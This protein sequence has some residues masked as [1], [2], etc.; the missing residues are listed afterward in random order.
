MWWHFVAPP[1]IYVICDVMIG[2]IFTGVTTGNP[3]VGGSFR[4]LLKDALRATTAAPTF[5]SPLQVIGWVRGN[6]NNIL[7][8]TSTYPWQK[9]DSILI[10]FPFCPL[11]F[12]LFP[13]P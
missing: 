7:S 12:L 3:N 4:F 5:F 1:F 2:P 13:P 8:L 10:P 9:A 11:S 6:N